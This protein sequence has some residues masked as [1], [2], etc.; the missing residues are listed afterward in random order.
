MGERSLIVWQCIII[1]C[2]IC[3]SEAA[4]Q[5]GCAARSCHLFLPSL[6]RNIFNVL[7]LLLTVETG[8]IHAPPQQ[9]QRWG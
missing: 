6:L 4:Y 2:I 3:T 5:R 8:H 1:V 7:C 9:R